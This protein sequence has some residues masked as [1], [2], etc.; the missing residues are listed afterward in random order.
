MFQ[1]TY[2]LHVNDCTQFLILVY[3]FEASVSPQKSIM[4][5]EELKYINE[6]PI[7]LF[8]NAS[9]RLSILYVL[10]LY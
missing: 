10:G 7:L 8:Y 3:A 6:N 2:N 1:S 4:N 9:D 5:M